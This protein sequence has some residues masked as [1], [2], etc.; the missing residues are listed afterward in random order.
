MRVF[1]IL[2]AV[3]MTLSS[4]P[5]T[6]FADRGASHL[7]PRHTD[8]D[9]WHTVCFFGDSTTY[10]LLVYNVRNKNTK[11]TNYKT[12]QT[13]Q[14]WVPRSG[15]FYLGNLFSAKIALPEGEFLL[16]EAAARKQPRHIILTVGI[17][18]LCT[19]KEEN[20]KK[21]YRKMVEIIRENSPQT[22]IYL[23]SVYPTARNISGKLQNFTND[24]VDRLNG[25]VQDIAK[26][27]DLLF[28][29]TASVLKDKEGF[30][31]PEYQ[32]GDGLHLNT[33][34]FNAI[35]KYIDQTIGSQTT[36]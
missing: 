9:F 30:L 27:K 31:F 6:A 35:L 3:A 20:F 23:Q 12:L 17:N 26:E 24:K 21:Y 14:I 11:V 10:G 25:W 33:Y 13:S 15:T 16:S 5:M 32:N 36:V 34:G 1:F 28:L 29:N 8:S 7:P 19:W 2:L 4:V 18:G 22:N